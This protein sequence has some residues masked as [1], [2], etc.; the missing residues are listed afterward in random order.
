[1]LP[2]IEQVAQDYLPNPTNILYEVDLDGYNSTEYILGRLG[3]VL[4]EDIN[5]IFCRRDMYYSG[6][7]DGRH[8]YLASFY[9]RMDYQMDLPSCV[10]SPNYDDA[11]EMEFIIYIIGHLKQR[12]LI[13]LLTLTHSKRIYMAAIKQLTWL[14]NNYIKFHR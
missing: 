13:E 6:L 8:Y 2:D 11:R 5:T 14:G 4:P 1:M 9:M 10:R 7:I 3:Y 12:S